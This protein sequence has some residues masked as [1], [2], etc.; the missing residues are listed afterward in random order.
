MELWVPL[1][2]TSIPYWPKCLL[3]LDRGEKWKGKDF[4]IF[5]ANLFLAVWESLGASVN[6]WGLLCPWDCPKATPLTSGRVND[7]DSDCFFTCTCTYDN[8]NH[9][10]RLCPGNKASS[11]WISMQLSNSIFKIGVMCAS[12]VPA[13]RFAWDLCWKCEGDV[14]F[15]RKKKSWKPSFVCKDHLDWDNMTW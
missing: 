9:F 13:D 14:R 12:F 11:F 3:Q 4:N 2:L 10:L 5:G 7:W 1:W 8:S 6:S 15:Q